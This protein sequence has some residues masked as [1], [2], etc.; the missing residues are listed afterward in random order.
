MAHPKKM[1]I[2]IL[3][4]YS[5]VSNTMFSRHTSF[6]TIV[7]GLSLIII[8]IIVFSWSESFS[9][10]DPIKSEKIGQLGDFIGGI[11][12]SIWALSGVILFYV[13][14]TLQRKEFQLQRRELKETRG[15]FEQQS[16]QLKIQQRE[17]TFFHLL[18]NHKKFID[19]F[20]EKARVGE[21][22]S[23]D[24]KIESGYPVIK[25]EWN[26]V[27]SDLKRYI[28]CINQS[29]IGFSSAIGLNPIRLLEKNEVF[30]SIY[31][32]I[33][34]LIWFVYSELENSEF[35]H[36]TIYY[37]L[38]NMERLA[39]GAYIEYN[40]GNSLKEINYSDINFDYTKDFKKSKVF[41]SKDK[42]AP[43]LHLNVNVKS[44]DLAQDNFE[45]SFPRFIMRASSEDVQLLEY[46]FVNK[47]EKFKIESVNGT[48]ILERNK[49]IEVDTFNFINTS[50][51]SGNLIDLVSSEN[52]DEVKE[53]IK[54]Y[55]VKFKFYA[56]VKH[57]D[58]E[59]T[60]EVNPSL[61]YSEAFG[62]Q[63]KL[64]IQ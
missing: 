7:L 47:D 11:V 27:T 34:H 17:N 39:L 37:N 31:T 20:S 41:L 51:Y 44:V 58:N 25:K 43:F 18:D 12:G 35:H 3:R 63:K 42:F 49:K 21:F 2:K 33:S 13:A 1:Q 57:N 62:K 60:L 48:E 19:S 5:K 64:T 61:H 36:M 32:N 9:T 29:T 54:G 53:I 40:A 23:N 26:T 16:K 24:Y 46:G 38:S 50:F 6:W 4:K 8:S 56:L 10:S 55:N 14:L 59:I 15:V 22:G 30:S 28:K 52:F 45:N